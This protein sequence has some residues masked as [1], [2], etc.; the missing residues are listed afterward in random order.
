MASDKFR[1]KA[2]ICRRLQQYSF[3]KPKSHEIAQ[4][5]QRPFIPHAQRG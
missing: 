1:R 2:Q 3:L 4:P 5:V